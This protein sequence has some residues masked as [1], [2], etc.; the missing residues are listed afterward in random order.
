MAK[1]KHLRRRKRT[2]SEKVILVLGVI[3]AISMILSLVVS[4]APISHAG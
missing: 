3:I 1:R 2:F 4:F